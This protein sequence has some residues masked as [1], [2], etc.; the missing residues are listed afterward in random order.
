MIVGI[1][2]KEVRYGAGYL[3]NQVFLTEKSAPVK[4]AAIVWGLLQERHI[5]LHVMM[6]YGDVFIPLHCGTVNY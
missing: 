3:L 4:G 2:P 5:N 6:P 1:N